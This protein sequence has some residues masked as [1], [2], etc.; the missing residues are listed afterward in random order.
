[1][2][3]FSFATRP[4]VVK[5]VDIDSLGPLAKSRVKQGTAS[6]NESDNDQ[7]SEVQSDDSSGEKRKKRRKLTNAQIQE[8]QRKREVWQVD[9]RCC[10]LKT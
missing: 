2:D 4:D 9:V 10:A 7:G 6:D 3:V 8:Q 5:V 1:V